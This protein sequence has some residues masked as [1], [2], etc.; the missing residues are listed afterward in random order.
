VHPTSVKRGRW[1][2]ALA[3]RFLIARG[4]ELLTANFTSR[5]GEIDLVMRDHDT[6]VF[7]EV[8]YRG[9]TRFA[10]AAESVDERKRARVARAAESY[11]Q[12]NPRAQDDPCRFDVVAIS[13]DGAPDKIRWI[14]HAFEA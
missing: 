10:D 14:K 1:A 3:K 7:V 11:L 12:R 9:R 5:V 2:E 6:T 13:G 4:L 8:R